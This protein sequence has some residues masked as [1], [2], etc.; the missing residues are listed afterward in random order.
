MFNVETRLLI[1]IDMAVHAGLDARCGHV[2][3]EFDFEQ[4]VKVGNGEVDRRWTAEFRRLRLESTYFCDTHNYDLQ[5][6]G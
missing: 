2:R 1:F 5:N 4:V 3:E 6:D